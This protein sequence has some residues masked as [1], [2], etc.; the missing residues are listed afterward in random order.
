MWKGVYNF[1]LITS[2]LY[3]YEIGEEVID[4]VKIADYIDLQA[5]NGN[6]INWTVALINNS[7]ASEADKFAFK[8]VF[9]KVGLTDRTN[10]EK[11][12]RI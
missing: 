12:G 9:E 3:K 2:F 5:K 6:L 10:V 1:N 8:G 11:V 7:T 4:T